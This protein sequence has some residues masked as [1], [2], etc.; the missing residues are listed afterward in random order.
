MEVEGVVKRR[1][2]QA[3]C[4]RDDLVVLRAVVLSI[5]GHVAIRCTASLH[6][7]LQVPQRQM[8]M[9]QRPARANDGY[10]K[11]VGTEHYC[12]RWALVALRIDWLYDGPLPHCT[13][14]RSALQDQSRAVPVIVCPPNSTA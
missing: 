1:H 10:Y 9:R 3:H 11:V 2:Q 7:V 14:G 6:A 13:M 4:H 5:D 12:A 8:T